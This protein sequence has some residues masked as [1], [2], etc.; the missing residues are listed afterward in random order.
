M[1]TVD[2]CKQITNIDILILS[3]IH[4]RVLRAN[5]IEIG[6]EFDMYLV[7]RKKSDL[8]QNM[9]YITATNA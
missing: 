5:I 9:P 1:T 4:G 7:L 6:S 8:L 2:L 3:N